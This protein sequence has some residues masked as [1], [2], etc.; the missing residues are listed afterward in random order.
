MTDVYQAVL[1]KMN[2]EID[3]KIMEMFVLVKPIGE[4]RL[5][6]RVVSFINQQKGDCNGVKTSY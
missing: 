1:K 5:V 2:R 3:K 4:D 6:Q